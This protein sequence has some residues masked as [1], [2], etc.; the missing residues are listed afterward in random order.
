MHKLKE[1][2]AELITENNQFKRL[3][4][5]LL[6]RTEYLQSIIEK[7]AA[8]STYVYN[9]P[10]KADDTLKKNTNQNEGQRVK[11]MYEDM[12]EQ[13]KKSFEAIIKTQTISMGEEIENLT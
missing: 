8:A 5:K 4:E 7:E 3:N 10:P 13:Q 6:D 9:Y 12:M 1:Q 11:K 2:N